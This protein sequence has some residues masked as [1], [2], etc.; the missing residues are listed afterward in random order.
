MTQARRVVVE[1]FGMVRHRA[2]RAEL[3]VRAATVRELL[4]AVSAS[5]PR[6]ADLRTADERLNRRVTEAL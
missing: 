2:G 5:C 6:L 4:D 3:S 1:F